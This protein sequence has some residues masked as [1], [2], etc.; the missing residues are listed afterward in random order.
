MQLLGKGSVL[1]AG[2]I[3]MP[4]IIFIFYTRA[5]P[6]FLIM[7]IMLSLGSAIIDYSRSGHGGNETR[8][9][10]YSAFIIGVVFLAEH[11]SVL[12]IIYIFYI[13]AGL[14]MAFS[15]AFY[16]SG[17]ME[18]NYRKTTLIKKLKR[19]I[20]SLGD[21]RRVRNGWT[22]M[23]AIMINVLLFISVAIALVTVPLLALGHG[24]SATINA[25]LG[26]AALS[27][28]AISLGSSIN[29]RVF[30]GISFLAIFPFLLIMGFL[31]SIKNTE[32]NLI[33]GFLMFPAVALFFPGYRK[34][35]TRKFPGSEIYYANK[36]AN[37]F[38]WIFIL[39]VPFIVLEFLRIPVYTIVIELIA[40]MAGL[41][42]I[43]KFTNYPEIIWTKKHK[44]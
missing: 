28:L 19:Y 39:P 14:I 38:S 29:S 21:I 31:I 8:S 18:I 34:Y 22:L 4:A 11:Y 27:F 3:I 37:F 35:F 32:F 9:Y 30:S 36:F 1:L 43:L 44:N 16:L 40:S 12:K 15:L 2:I 17:H 6:V 26:I 23:Y 10:L 7:T 33:T 24:G 5:L 42:M 25:F 41:I 20:I 13:I